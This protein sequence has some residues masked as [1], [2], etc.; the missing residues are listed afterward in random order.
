V[1]EPGRGDRYL[2]PLLED[3]LA[4]LPAVLSL[5]AVETGRRLGHAPTLAYALD[6]RCVAIW[7][8]QETIEERQAVT[9]EPV[10]V[11]EAAGDSCDR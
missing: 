4:A 7:A 2:L 8:P 10:E 11:A 3:A 1:W 6:G 5:E 9:S